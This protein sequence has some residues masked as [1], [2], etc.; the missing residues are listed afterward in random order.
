MSIPTAD[1]ADT[2][3][4]VATS[5][6]SPDTATRRAT[7]RVPHLVLTGG[8]C[9]GKSTALGHLR[10]Q[11]GARGW[12]VL[13]VPEAATTLITSGLED[14]GEIAATDPATFASV[15]ESVVAAQI[16]L[17]DAYNRLAQSLAA[18][19]EKVV[20]VHDRGIADNAAYVPAKA[21]EAAIAA[22]GLDRVEVHALYTAVL[23]LRSA[24]VPDAGYAGTAYTVENNAAR[25][26]TPQEAAD[27]DHATL[28]GWAE[29][30][31]LHVIGSGE[32][33]DVKLDR[34]LAAALSVLGDPDPVEVERKFALEAAPDLTHPVLAA[35]PVSRIVQTYLP[36]TSEGTEQRVRARFTAGVVSFCHTTKAPVSPT[37]RVEVER[38]ISAET[39]ELLTG[40]RDPAT[41][42]VIKD[43]RVFIVGNHRFELDEFHVPAAGWLLEV[44]LIDENDQ[45]EVPAFLGAVREVTDDPSWRNHALAHRAP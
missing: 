29:H 42:P 38:P 11:L 28:A 24:A 30:P 32:A 33:F 40:L 12:R 4:P 17:R 36:S 22:F 9:A 5:P 15:Q 44:E 45:V 34:V 37:R 3:E 2:P 13:I 23:H 10:R 18:R 1:H 31:H 20:V 27:L 39:Y 21:Y 14:L 6:D 26:E 8:P 19:G 43:R 7:Q 16:G 35:A 41:T 25:R